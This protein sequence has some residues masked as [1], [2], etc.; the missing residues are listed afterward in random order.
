MTSQ[1]AGEVALTGLKELPRWLQ[2]APEFAAVAQALRA[3][4]A[5][6]I[7]GAWNSSA[8]LAVAALGTHQG[9]AH[10]VSG[11]RRTS[12]AYSVRGSST[13]LIVLA[14]P[15]DLDFWA[16]DLASFTGERPVI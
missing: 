7:D 6:T 10:E 5:A 15:R 9:A 3:G 16:G 8:A 1:R 2:T 12:A 11:K 13:L 4:R 14:H